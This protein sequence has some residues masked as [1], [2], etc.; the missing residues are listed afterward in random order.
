LRSLPT[1]FTPRREFGCEIDRRL[2]AE[3]EHH[4]RGVRRVVC[5]LYFVRA[6]RFENERVG[7]VEIGRDRFGIVVDDHGRATGL[8]QRPRRVHATV[9][10]LDTLPDPNRTAPDHDDRFAR[11]YAHL[12]VLVPR[13]IVVRRAR[14]KLG[15]R[16]IDHT[17]CRG[18]PVRGIALERLR[19]VPRENVRHVLGEARDA[20]VRVTAFEREPQILGRG[21]AESLLERDEFGELPEPERIDRRHL[22]EIRDRTPA[23]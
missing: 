21:R 22:G 18:T 12:V 2:A 8:A 5:R 17:E 11:G 7:Y 19:I 1:I 13:E 20:R 15:R 23:A 6:G 16:R 3:R 4:A 10:E 14:R 9:V